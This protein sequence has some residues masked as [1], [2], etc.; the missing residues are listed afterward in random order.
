MADVDRSWRQVPWAT[1]A[2]AVVNRAQALGGN[3]RPTRNTA[4]RGKGL[5][6]DKAMG[7]GSSSNSRLTVFGGESVLTPEV[8]SREVKT[9]ALGFNF[10]CP[11]GLRSEQVTWGKGVKIYLGFICDLFIY[12]FISSSSHHHLPSLVIGELDAGDLISQ[13]GFQPPR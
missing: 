4:S 7:N 1:S 2:V 3:H 5:K 11:A 6:V 13:S 9:A 10:L 12:F 8:Q